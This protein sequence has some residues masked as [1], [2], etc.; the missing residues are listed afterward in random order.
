ML[1]KYFYFLWKKNV[2]FSF[3]M[4]CNTIS[5]NKAEFQSENL[6]VNLLLTIMHEIYNL[7]DN[8]CKGFQR[9]QAKYGMKV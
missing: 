8:A 6:I 1:I 2:K 4:K 7:F 3:P 9:F 5:L